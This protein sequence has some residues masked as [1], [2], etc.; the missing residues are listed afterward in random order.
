MRPGLYDFETL[1][2]FTN[3]AGTI[4]NRVCVNAEVTSP[5]EVARFSR[6]MPQAAVT[7]DQFWLNR[8]ASTVLLRFLRDAL[9]DPRVQCPPP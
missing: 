1:E 9:G 7:F 8:V 3:L 6:S 5:P 4:H 2:D